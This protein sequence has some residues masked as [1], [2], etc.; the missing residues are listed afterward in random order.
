MYT[1]ITEV[2]ECFEEILAPG[3]NILWQYKTKDMEQS[4]VVVKL[5]TF[6]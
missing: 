1:D 4:Q 6:K 2:L 5:M 3:S